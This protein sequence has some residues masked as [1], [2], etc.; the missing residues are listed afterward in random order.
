MFPVIKH[1]LF[2]LK[3]LTF[4]QC[5]N[6]SILSL[7]HDVPGVLIFKSVVHRPSSDKCCGWNIC[8]A[9]HNTAICGSHRGDA[10]Y[11]Q[12]KKVKVKL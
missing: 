5:S 8:P 10:P 2:C 4:L 3:I 9:S 11:L 6:R 12:K 7:K 1:K